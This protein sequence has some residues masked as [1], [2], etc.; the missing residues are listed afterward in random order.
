[1][2][3]EIESKV[4]DKVAELDT[5]LSDYSKGLGLAAIQ[6]DKDIETILEMSH[7]DL[8]AM[9]SEDA[10]IWSF[11]LARYAG[12]LQKEINRHSAKNK[13]AEHNIKVIIAKNQ[14]NYGDKYT[15]YEV[16]RDMIIAEN[17]YAQ[18]LNKLLLQS[19]LRIEELNFVS[20]RIHTMSNILLDI[21]KSKRYGD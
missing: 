16:K 2:S 14:G 3:G 11:R 5:L 12:F 7:E 20:T 21:S 17:S 15:K 4:D 9:D 1:M 8:K 10:G 19:M 13:W 18:V 6:K